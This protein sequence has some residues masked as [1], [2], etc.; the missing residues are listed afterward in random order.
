MRISKCFGECRKFFYTA[1]MWCSLHLSLQRTEQGPA[2]KNS[3]WI[4]SCDEGSLSPTY[5]PQAWEDR[6]LKITLLKDQ[7]YKGGQQDISSYKSKEQPKS[8]AHTGLQNIRKQTIPLRGPRVSNPCS[9]SLFSEYNFTLL[10]PWLDDRVNATLW[11]DQ[12]CH[13]CVNTQWWV[14]FFFWLKLNC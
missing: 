10:R 6:K 7:S 9:H 5:S 12:K 14:W 13:D 4:D 11:L 8:P 1:I 2:D 3:K